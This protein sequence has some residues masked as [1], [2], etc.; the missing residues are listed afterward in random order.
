MR[1]KIL[2][3][4]QKLVIPK[5]VKTLL[6]FSNFSILSPAIPVYKIVRF[7]K[8]DRLLKSVLL[9]SEYKKQINQLNFK[10]Q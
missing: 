4:S 1:F 10:Y 2:L 5:R 3:E 7:M 6:N 9:P 8:M